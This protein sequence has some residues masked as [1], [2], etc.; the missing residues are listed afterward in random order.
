MSSAFFSPS[1]RSV[2]LGRPSASPCSAD[3]TSRSRG[4]AI[5]RSCEILNVAWRTDAGVARRPGERQA[6]R[7]GNHVGTIEHA[8]ELHRAIEIGREVAC[9]D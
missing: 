8:I 4:G 9:R 5:P 3:G 1:S 6:E 2:A 7:V